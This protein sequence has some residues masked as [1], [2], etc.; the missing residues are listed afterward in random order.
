MK[1]NVGNI[2]R[3][4]RIVLGVVLGVVGFLVQGALAVVSLILGA[5]LLITGLVGRC[6]L[7]LPFGINTCKVEEAPAENPE[8][9]E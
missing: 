5:V 6:G 9:Q 2:D 1:Q 4:L 7:Y 8:G 3:V